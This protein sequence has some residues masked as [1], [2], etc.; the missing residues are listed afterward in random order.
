MADRS[1]RST[2]SGGKASDAG[3]FSF[4]TDC[5]FACFE[6]GPDGEELPRVGKELV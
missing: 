1:E 2:V 4:G 6:P 3:S 5:A